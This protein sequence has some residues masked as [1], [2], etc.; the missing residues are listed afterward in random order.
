MAS[1]KKIINVPLFLL[2]LLVVAN[3]Q[4][5]TTTFTYNSFS[6]GTDSLLYQGDAFVPSSSSFVRLTKV[7][8]SGQPERSS[9]GRVVYAP[10]VKFW[11]EGLQATFETTIR[12][13]V[14]P[15]ASGSVGDGFNFFIVPVNSVIP[16][17]SVDGNLGLFDPQTGNAASVF[18]VEF[19]IAPNLAWD[20]THQHIGIDI[21]S[22]VS[23][24]T[25][26]FEN[27]VGEEVTA[28]INYVSSTRTI[29]VFATYGSLNSTVSYVFDLK[30][31][32]PREVQVGI[33]ATTGSWIAFHDLHA[34][35]FSS[36]LVWDSD[37]LD[38]THIRQYV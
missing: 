16:P 12:F 36:S 20:P 37:N 6:T 30:T 10:P 35:Y 18:A 23:R 8:A 38:Q 14:T 22:R 7:N 32:L 15:G 26:R 4:G 29:T 5:D 13:T 33:S 3:S 24:N 9:I 31:I 34:W 27:S 21:N 11:E 25:S 17:G 28:R 1:Q 19:D 2:M